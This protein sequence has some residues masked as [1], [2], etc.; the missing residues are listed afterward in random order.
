MKKLV[1]STVLVTTTSI[2]GG[3]IMLPAVVGIHGYIAAVSILTAVCFI[4]ILLALIFLEASCYLAPNTNLISMSQQLLGRYAKWLTWIMSL[5]FLYTLLCV[6][7]SGLTEIIQSLLSQY[8]LFIPSYYLSISLVI[9]VS[10][11]IYFST[12]YFH[13]F[14]RI[15]VICLFLAFFTLVYQII[16]DIN[17]R[18]LLASTNHIPVMSLPI[19]FTSFGFLIVLP[20][21]RTYLEDNTKKIRL[22][23]VVGSM[24]PLIVYIL[25]IT[26][27]MGI[28]PTAGDNSLQA[29]VAHAEPI[30][31]MTE[32][33]ISLSNNSSISFFIQIFILFAISGSFI[34]VSLGLNEFIID[35]FKLKKT[36]TGKLKALALTFLPPLV[37]TLSQTHVFL[38]GLGFVGFLVTILFGIYPL[39]FAWSGRYIRKLP[40][41]YRAPANRFVFFLLM[42]FCLVILGVE[43]ISFFMQSNTKL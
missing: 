22:A 32:S 11:P 17:T 38:T 40:T 31:K 13:Y 35:G 34:G 41:H 14:N 30:K 27:V 16:P 18:N 3:M 8:V 6:Y 23:I 2:G 39:I 29:I 12:T 43:V 21:L 42:V 28:I 15:I 1:Y 9:L 36:Y 24:I 20:Y 26:A 4:N 5:V 25:W 33:L 19:V 10:F 7:I 37:I